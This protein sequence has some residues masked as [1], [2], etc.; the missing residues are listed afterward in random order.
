[1]R[2]WSEWKLANGNPL[3]RIPKEN[4]SLVDHELTQEEQAKRKTLVER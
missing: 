1:M 2:R 3:V 4:A